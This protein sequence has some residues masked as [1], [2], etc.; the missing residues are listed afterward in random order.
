MQ[1]TLVPSAAGLKGLCPD[2]FL[3]SFLIN[4]TVGLDAGCLGL[5]GSPAE[6]ARVKHLLLT[7]SHLDHLASLPMLIDNTYTGTGD[8]LTVY[9]SEEV[10]DSLRRDVFN[11]RLWP[12]FITMSRTQ[13]PFVRLQPLEP[14]RTVEVAGLR[15][16]P[17]PV[18]HVVP[19]LGYIIEDDGA[20][21]AFSSDTA[22]TDELWERANR[23][24]NLKAV[25]LEATFPEALDWLAK[26]AYHLTP[27]RFAAEA[28][29]LT[30]PVRLI[31]VHI[32]PRYHAQV[33]KELEALG[34]PGLE[35]GLF[36]ISYQF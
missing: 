17:V 36:G 31:A 5:Y 13:P 32:K 28:R 26:L 18:N 34:L 14:G 20:A 7:H 6:Q 29:K 30:R 10:L 15:V 22:P 23:T 33:V 12:D 9:G 1:V 25:F 27:S 3:T 4:D 2:Q 19:T 24:P 11:N 21:V 8:C 16:T 35:I